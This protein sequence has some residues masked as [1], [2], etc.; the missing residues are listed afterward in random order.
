MSIPTQRFTQYPAAST[1]DY[2]DATTFLIAN[3]DGEIKQASLDGFLDNFLCGV[4]C[5]E[6]TIPSANVLT[7]NSSPYEIVA[8][9]GVGKAIQAIS[10]F[11]N[12][13]FNSTPYA[14][15][16]VLTLFT[17]TIVASQMSN[18]VLSMVTQRYSAFSPVSGS[19]LQNLSENSS[20]KA[21]VLSGDPTAGDSDIAVYVLYRVISL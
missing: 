1:G 8:A 15:N 19:G 6:V 18:D 17:N 12:L 13:D 10:G 9:P 14:T 21:G 11:V 7:L 20:L 2:A 3:E 5:A 4:R 16:T